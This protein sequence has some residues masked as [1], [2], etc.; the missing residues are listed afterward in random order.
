MFSRQFTIDDYERVNGALDV[1]TE[2]FGPGLFIGENLVAM[3]RTMGFLAD[4]KFKAAL[5]EAAPT[6]EERAIV[7]RVHT[8]AWAARRALALPGD[9]VDV[10]VRQGFEAAVVGRYLDFAQS[11]KRW[12]LFDAFTHWRFPPFPNAAASRFDL[13]P[14]TARRLAFM[15]NAQIER[16]ASLLDLDKAPEAI[17]FL[18][19]EDPD[20]SMISGAL[21]KLFPKLCSG[22]TVVIDGYGA[23][24]RRADTL[25]R[26][27]SRLD[28]P[29]LELPTGQGLLIKR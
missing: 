16:L 26:F 28:H 20:P 19:I 29:I 5:A 4:E 10:G 23:I 6:I 8:I 14:F 11:D 27:L 9:F 22:A 2:V 3:D 13:Q 18:R 17:A 7:W 24:E 12:A 21:N 25:D 1:L 15:P